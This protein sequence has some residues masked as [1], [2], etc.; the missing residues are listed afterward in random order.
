MEIT[1]LVGIDPGVDT[2][3]AVRN[4][5]TDEWLTV[6]SMPIHEA[7]DIV[8][9]PGTFVIFEDARM[10]GGSP[11]TRLGAGSVRRD[12]QIWEDYL[13]AKKIPFMKVSPKQKGRK[14]GSKTF[15]LYTGWKLQT[16][17]HGRD[18]AMC[19]ISYSKTS[20]KLLTKN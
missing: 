10:R 12:S 13:T 5:E 2:G 17:Q 18:A 15:K 7:M 16:N 6:T 8:L 1:F 11:E 14:V 3:V 20:L 9:T 19:I 4:L